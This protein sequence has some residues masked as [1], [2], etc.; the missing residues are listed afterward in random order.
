MQE[1]SSEE[2]QLLRTSYRWPV[3]PY[4]WILEVMWRHAVTLRASP[5]LGSSRVG[6]VLTGSRGRTLC[7]AAAL[8]L[9]A[10]GAP[11]AARAARPAAVFRWCPTVS[12]LRGTLHEQ[13]H[14]LVAHTGPLA[15]TITNGFAPPAPGNIATSTGLE[16]T[17][18]YL[19]DGAPV[20]ISFLAPVTAAT[21]GASRSAARKAGS[22]V[23]IRGLG[24]DAWA[25]ASGGE[26]FVR[27][28]SLDIVLS[29]PGAAGRAL[30]SLASAVI[31]RYPR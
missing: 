20:T 26:L 1:A 21:F 11:A 16:R 22:I 12:L 3:E 30:K 31:A 18:N 19:T 8:A 25:P 6:G 15:S 9:L 13:V 27:I 24:D 23:G 7:A 2:T 14:G 17:C 5:G 4:A 28:D 10:A 29:A